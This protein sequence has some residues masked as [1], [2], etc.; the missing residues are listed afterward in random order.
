MTISIDKSTTTLEGNNSNRNFDFNFRVWEEDELELWEVINSAAPVLIASDFT[1]TLNENQETNPGGT[2]V[3]P[4]AADPLTVNDTLTIRRGMP[5]IQE[6]DWVNNQTF[7]AEVIE[8]NF[9]IATAERQEL[10]EITDRCLKT[11]PGSEIEIDLDEFLEDWA[12]A[13]QQIEDAVDEAESWANL[14]QAY[15]EQAQD[16][17]E[18][19]SIEDYETTAV[20]SQTDYTMPFT[21]NV[22]YKNVVV[23]VQGIKQP[24]SSYSI[25]DANTV[26]FSEAPPAGYLLEFTSFDTEGAVEIDSLNIKPIGDYSNNLWNAVNSIGA[27]PATLL[28]DEATLVDQ[29]TVVP[30][31]LSLWVIRTGYMYDSNDSN[32]TINGTLSAP[33]SQ[34]IFNWTGTGNVFIG[35]TSSREIYP[36]WWGAVADD[37]TDDY[38]AIQ[39]SIES[40][41]SG[42]G[43]I[44]FKKGTY[45]IDSH[46]DL[47]S[48][49]DVRLAFDHP[50][51]I[52]PTG[53]SLLTI[54][55][56]YNIIATSNQRIFDNDGYNFIRF[57]DGGDVYP[58]WWGAVAD[59][60]TS[61]R[62]EINSAMEALQSTTNNEGTVVLTSGD[63]Q[64]VSTDVDFTDDPNIYLKILPSARFSSSGA[65]LIRLY[66][67]SNLIAQPNQH[68]LDGD[69]LKFRYGGTVHPEWWGIDGVEDEVEINY[70]ITSVETASGNN[71][72]QLAAKRYLTNDEIDITN[73]GVILRGA[74]SGTEG[75]SDQRGTVI[76][77][78]EAKLYHGIRIDDCEG[79]VVEDLSILGIDHA[80]D[81]R[82]IYASDTGG[83]HRFKNVNVSTL[84]YGFY[85]GNEV[86]GCTFEGCNERD[87][88]QAGWDIRGECF[89]TVID[90]CSSRGD[91]SVSLLGPVIRL[92][93]YAPS[94]GVSITNCNFQSKNRAYMLDV[95]QGG[96]ISVNGNVFKPE[97]PY[98]PFLVRLGETAAVIGINFTG[99][100]FEGD[101]STSITC[102]RIIDSP[103]IACK[104]SA[105]VFKG[106]NTAVFFDDTSTLHLQCQF[107]MTNN[108]DTAIPKVFISDRPNGWS[109]EYLFEVPTLDNFAF[110][111]V[112]P[113]N[114]GTVEFLAIDKGVPVGG[115]GLYN[116]DG[117][118]MVE[119]SKTGSNVAFTTGVLNGFTGVNGNLTISVHTNGRI[120]IENRL[121][122]TY[123]LQV[124]VK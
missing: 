49:Q 39:A 63:Y 19:L 86:V 13:L 120:Y 37:V 75:A 18:N 11:L 110:W 4:V 3:Y 35:G 30:S 114:K 53:G 6:T 124:R 64:L 82:G 90:K 98:A 41:A 45:T 107:D 109:A 55:S 10:K 12:Q 42:G 102:F 16:I 80:F 85:I 8:E 99:N 1:I 71:V 106:F 56:P 51:M 21:M 59:G 123:R 24:R 72:I 119:L 91:Q 103:I 33:D 48:N 87:C 65:G 2:V 20:A 94:Y 34:K 117:P 68:V 25:P 5:F 60:V 26:R 61:D 44:R 118:S 54:H 122:G 77:L 104:V 50:A 38:A 69:K 100:R 67:P 115:V 101:D 40:L 84:G 23:Y 22:T 79:A 74:A 97:S 57:T 46:L 83:Y 36:E 28:I 9:D 14:S 96:S 43:I 73:E 116:E 93:M 121:G 70:A 27:T 78:A 88:E 89:G 15:A 52:D 81:R 105:N 7:D 112:P 95:R 76:Y 66:S 32:L 113:A 62:R 58:E 17:V 92:G 29:N 31:T 108:V 111:F 47:T